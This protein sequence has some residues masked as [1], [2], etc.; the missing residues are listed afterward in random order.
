MDKEIVKGEIGSEGE[1][2]LE[3]KDGKLRMTV[4]YD[5]KGVNTGVYLD[6]EPD[7]FLDKLKEAIPGKIDDIIIDT[8]KAA[9]LNS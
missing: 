2:S 1:Y 3:I 8:L 4:G 6:L 9:F 7:Y 5:G